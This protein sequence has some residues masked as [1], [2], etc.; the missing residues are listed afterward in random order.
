ME[1]TDDFGKPWRYEDGEYTVTRS[2]V[3][4]P[5]GCH[6][7][8]CSLKLYVDKTGRLVKVEG[9]END[10][11]THG[12][13]CPRCLA[14]KDYIYNP[15]RVVYPMYRKPED[16]GKDKWERIS[17]DDAIQMIMDKWNYYTGLYG[18]ETFVVF[19]GTGRDGM[20][21]ASFIQTIFRTPN[22]VYTQS[23]YACYQPRSFTCQ[24]VMGT[25]YPEIDYA[26]GLEGGYENPEYTVPEVIVLWGKDPLQSNP[27]GFFGHSITDMMQ[28]GSKLVMVDPRVNWLSTRSVVHLRLRPGTDGAMAM[29][30]ANIII[31]ED[32]YD[33]D[34]VEK[35]C[36]GFDEFAERVAEMTPER[37]AEICEVS[38]D[39]LLLA[40]RTYALAKPAAI[41][42]GLAFDQNQNGSQ[43]AHC[44]IACMALTG[45]IDVPGGQVVGEL[46]SVADEASAADDELEDG[47]S[48]NEEVRDGAGMGGLSRGTRQM[49]IGWYAMDEET[50]SKCIGMDKYPLFCTA[51]GAHADCMLDALETDDPYPLRMGWIQSSNLMAATNSAESDRWHRAMCRSLEF[52]FGT[53]CFITPT[54]QATCDL[55]LP[56]STVAEHNSTNSTH[57]GSATINTG[58]TNKAITVGEAKSDQEI[59][60]MLAKAMGGDA[61]KIFQSDIQWQEIMRLRGYCTFEELKEKVKVTRHRKYRKYEIGM[62]RPD[63]LPGFN[64]PTG[65]VELWSTQYQRGGEDPLPYYLEPAFSPVSK[66]DLAREYPFILTTGARTT[67]FFHSEHRQIPLLRE[68]NPNPLLEINPE[69]A[70]DLGLCDGQWVMIENSFGKAKLKAKVSP[71]VRKGVVMAQHGWWFPEQDSEEPNLFGV[72]QSNINTLIPNHYNNKIGYGAP[73]KNMNC[74]VAP[75]DVS[76]DTDMDLVWEKFGKLVD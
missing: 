6:P 36:Y 70:K 3:W 61:A 41:G 17:W 7:V 71:I 62:L 23:G 33:H 10:P 69:D 29:A 53:D 12:R 75:L 37:A 44:V 68:L 19:Q 63:G 32:L 46:M 27:D 9:D 64:T 30:W 13:L 55:F 57:Y 51:T 35:W 58:A 8:G 22:V 14:L 65:R 50:R 40:V 25:F 5:P 38:V 72:W 26:G 43:A 67:A 76:Y 56:L 1:F 24:F 28:R 48:S 11:V 60:V 52:C 66:P 59:E 15:S 74:R 18:K 34:F 2:S 31:T 16:R 54:I 49:K 39:D 73:Y 4:S 21:T 47:A 20:L 45:N 42:W